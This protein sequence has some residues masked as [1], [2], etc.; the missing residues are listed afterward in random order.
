MD[1]ARDRVQGRF[2]VAGARL[3]W[4]LEPMGRGFPT[5]HGWLKMED[6]LPED[7]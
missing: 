5:G 7:P 4:P 1:G 2:C 6:F 3:A